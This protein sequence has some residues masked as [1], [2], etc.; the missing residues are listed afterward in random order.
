MV[1]NRARRVA[2]WAAVGR[3]LIECFG[4]AFW[5]RGALIFVPTRFFFGF[6]KGG[7]LGKDL[8]FHFLISFWWGSKNN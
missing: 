4:S 6:L 7:G 8:V 5:V 2:I 3:A 1:S